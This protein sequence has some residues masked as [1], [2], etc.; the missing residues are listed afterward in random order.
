MSLNAHAAPTDVQKTPAFEKL[1]TTRIDFF[2]NPVLQEALRDFGQNTAVRFVVECMNGGKFNDPKF[3]GPHGNGIFWSNEQRGHCHEGDFEVRAEFT[4]TDSLMKH[5]DQHGQGKKF[6][7]IINGSRRSG[8]GV[9]NGPNA[10][11]ILNVGKDPQNFSLGGLLVGPYATFDNGTVATLE[12]FIKC[13][14]AFAQEVADRTGTSTV[15]DDAGS[16]LQM[17]LSLGNLGYE[18]VEQ[19]EHT[20]VSSGRKLRKVFHPKPNAAQIAA[21]FGGKVADTVSTS[22]S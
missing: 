13:I 19:A 17:A 20:G 11:F 1:F 3:G 14:D 22:Q 7:F 10:G 16:S 4:K 5:F 21:E 2:T 12:A 6:H 8:V 9:N 15:V 18:V